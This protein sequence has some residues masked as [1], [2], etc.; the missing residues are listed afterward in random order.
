MRN[1]Y[2]TGMA[3]C[4]VAI[5]VV[6]APS[7]IASQRS[8]TGYATQLTNERKAALARV[9]ADSLKSHVSFLASDAL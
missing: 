2:I 3:L 4:I 7:H 9:D 5:P 1:P 8:P 6:A